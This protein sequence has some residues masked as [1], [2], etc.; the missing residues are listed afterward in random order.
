[1]VKIHQFT[2]NTAIIIAV[3]TYEISTWHDVRP[4]QH[5]SVV[6][7]MIQAISVFNYKPTSILT[8]SQSYLYIICAMT[9]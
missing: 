6:H 4:L 7:Y 2:S 9:C 5:R 1:M 8:L 3:M